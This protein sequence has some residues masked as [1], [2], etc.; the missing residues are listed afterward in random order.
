MNNL[1][2]TVLDFPT[3]VNTG[4]GIQNKELD[5]LKEELQH[6]ERLGMEKDAARIET[7]IKE[8]AVATFLQNL[9]FNL[10]T[11]GEPDCDGDVNIFRIEN[12]GKH[13]GLHISLDGNRQH[14]HRTLLR[15]YVHPIPLEIL[16]KLPD[17]AGLKTYVFSPSRDLD[18]ILAFQ[19]TWSE[20]KAKT[21]VK[22]IFRLKKRADLLVP[23]YCPYWIGLYEWE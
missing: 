18:P 23:L 12:S 6:Y 13:K 22:S 16:R 3:L 11:I 14:F 21:F 4:E 20:T 1:I 8:G 2:P 19:M 17:E 10:L 7:Q 5:D 9:G 15:D